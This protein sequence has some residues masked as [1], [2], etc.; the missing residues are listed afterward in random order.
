MKWWFCSEISSLVGM[1]Y[2]SQ[3]WYRSITQLPNVVAQLIQT[4]E[5]Y[6]RAS[7]KYSDKYYTWDQLAAACVIDPAVVCET[8]SVHASVELHCAERL[9]QMVVDLNKSHGKTE[10]VSIVTKVNHALYKKLI[11]AALSIF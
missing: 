7:K 1:H 10:N 9:G 8:C 5:H 3:E 4:D 6:R 11:T 2:V